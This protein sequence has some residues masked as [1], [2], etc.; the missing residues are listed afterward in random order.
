MW[1]KQTKTK[2]VALGNHDIAY[3]CTERQVSSICLLT[4]SLCT[5]SKYG[6]GL[7]HHYGISSINGIWAWPSPQMATSTGRCQTFRGGCP[8]PQTTDHPAFL[9]GLR[10]PSPSPG[11]GSPGANSEPKLSGCVCGGGA[12]GLHR[13]SRRALYRGSRGARI[14]AIMHPRR[15]L[16]KSTH[17]IFI[18]LC[19]IPTCAHG[20]V[21]L[22]FLQVILSALVTWVETYDGTS[23]DLELDGGGNTTYSAPPKN[24]AFHRKTFWVN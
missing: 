22:A 11:P 10:H 13:S 9:G 6:D 18:Y 24:P 3:V 17:L 23:H 2:L 4:R 19:L 14:W 20:R 1:C 5:R 21:F 12:Q 16:E 7:Y 15:C 8:A